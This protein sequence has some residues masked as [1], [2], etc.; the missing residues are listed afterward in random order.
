[1]NPELLAKFPDAAAL[2]ILVALLVLMRRRYPSLATKNWLLALTF[3]FISQQDRF[4]SLLPVQ[5][6][7]RLAVHTLLVVGQILAAL[8]LACYKRPNQKPG[9]T[10]LPFL[11]FNAIPLLVFSTLYGYYIFVVWPYMVTAGAGVVILLSSSFWRKKSIPLA[12]VG[13]ICFGIAAALAYGLHYRT[14][15]YWLLFCVF[16]LAIIRLRHALPNGS[17]GKYV[18]LTS[19]SVWAVSFLIHPWAITMPAWNPLAN[20]L[21]DLQKFF[22]CIGMLLVLLEDQVTS[23]QWLALHDQLTDLPN[24]R[25]IDDWLDDAIATARQTGNGLAVLLID[26]NGFKTINDTCGHA[27]GDYVLREVAQRMQSKLEKHEMLA[28]LGGD[29]FV[30]VS[31]QATSDEDIHRIEIRLQEA[32]QKPLHIQGKQLSVSGTFGASTYPEDTLNCD[33]KRIA[34]T[35]LHISDQRMYQRKTAR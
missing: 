10:D 30:I 32:I 21:W 9:K 28:R 33:P 29:E 2:P 27:V 35:L 24:R 14:A 34:A 1:M 25:L 16:S 12:L 17:I 15:E 13:S 18:I 6:W 3:I 5:H 7:L 19:L 22:L 20:E 11:I 8:T 26:L 23:T 31:P 4:V